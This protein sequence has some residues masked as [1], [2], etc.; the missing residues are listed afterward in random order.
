MSAA[1]SQERTM[2]NGSNAEIVRSLIQRFFNGHNPS[3]AKEYFV[4]DFK[5]HG[6]SVGSYQGA[7]K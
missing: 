1:Q 7:E 5:W 3:L 4:P 6:G 2:S